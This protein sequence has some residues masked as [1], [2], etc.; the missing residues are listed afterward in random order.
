MINCFEIIST[1]GTKIIYNQLWLDKNWWRLCYKGYL[2]E[3]LVIYISG[4]TVFTSQNALAR[5]ES[6]RP[7]SSFSLA[8]PLRILLFRYKQIIINVFT[9]TYN[10]IGKSFSALKPWRNFSLSVPYIEISQVGRNSSSNSWP[11]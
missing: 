5:S 9:F 11:D 6:A 2:K 8:K 1:K 10:R 7:K 4:E 3:E